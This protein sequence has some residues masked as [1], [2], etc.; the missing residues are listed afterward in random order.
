MNVFIATTSTEKGQYRTM[1]DRTPGIWFR[2]KTTRPIICSAVNWDSNLCITFNSLPLN[3]YS[4][5]VIQQIQSLEDKEY[6]YQ[7]IINGKRVLNILSTSPQVFNN[8]KYYASDPWYRPAKAFIKGFE[9]KLLQHEGNLTKCRL[10][11]RFVKN[12]IIY[13]LL[14]LGI[15]TAN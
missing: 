13:A 14:N 7:I 4:S 9:L 2:K 12:D 1:G 6:Y 3:E 10:R 11:Q 5:I 8:V 15:D